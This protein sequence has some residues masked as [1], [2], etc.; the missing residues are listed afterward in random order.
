M[1]ALRHFLDTQDYSAAGLLG[2]IALT[3]LLKAAARDGYYPKLLP[4]ASLA[5]IF[6]EPSTR[7]RLSFEVA[8]T[9]LGGHAL[10]L[11][12]GEILLGGGNIHGITQ[13]QPLAAKAGAH[14]PQSETH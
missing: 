10:Y 14:A 4:D 6:E 7:T 9:Q 3:R 1:P 12:P 13:Q 11:K 8:M 2:I 5:M